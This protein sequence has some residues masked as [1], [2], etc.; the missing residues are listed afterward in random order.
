MRREGVETLFDAKDLALIGIFEVVSHIPKIA[1]IFN[2]LVKEAKNRRPDAAVLIDS[3]DFNLRLAG[4]LKRAGIPVLYYISPTVW[5]WRPGRL[6]TIRK[7]VSKMMLIFPFEEEIYRAH[8]IPAVY[9]GHPLREKVTAD[10]SREDFFS[11]H[12]FDLS[13]KLVTVLPGSRKN[14]LKNHMPVLIKVMDRLRAGGISQFALVLAQT[15]RRQDLDAFA[16]TEALKCAIL[17][18]NGYEAMAAS[19]LVLSSC[20]SANLEAALLGTPVISFY[21]L[22][23]PTYALGIRLMRI[24]NYSIVNILA[25]QRIIP[26]LIQDRFDEESLFAEARKILDSPETCREMKSHFARIRN[27][28]GDRKASENAARELEKLISGE[29]LPH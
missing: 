6:K 19:D 29:N 16:P 7:S 2:R 27:L 8:S 28:L 9:V 11:R 26:E 21:R 22:S 5:A 13:K 3:P 14:E 25:Q 12:D 15:L 10:L 17:D 1:K 23:R 4:K 20:G 18:E 24:R